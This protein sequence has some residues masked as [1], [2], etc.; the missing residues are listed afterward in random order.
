MK[1]LKIPVSYIDRL[2]AYDDMIREPFSEQFIVFP[3]MVLNH[4]LKPRI[5]AYECIDEYSD[6]RHNGVL[7]ITSYTRL[8]IKN[9]K[10]I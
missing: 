3:G 2:L 8:K 5:K 7:D 6:K 1:I 10:M 4:I 9:I